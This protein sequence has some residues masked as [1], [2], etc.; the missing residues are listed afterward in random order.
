MKKLLRYGLILTCTLLCSAQLC[1]ADT[2][3]KFGLSEIG[4]DVQFDGT[5]FSTSNDGD[6]TTPGD[7]NT[8]L[9]FVGP[10]LGV[11]PDILAGAS[12]SI[13][14]VVIDGPALV[15]GPSVT[16]NTTGGTFSVWDD[17][18]N[19]LLTG[20]LD[21]SVL[22][23]SLIGSTGSYFNTSIVTLTGGSLLPF[24]H[25]DSGGLS[26]ALAGINSAGGGHLSVDGT[27]LLP[28]S[29]NADGLLEGEPIPEPATGLL[30]LTGGALLARRRKAA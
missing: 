24:F 25:P 18:D 17:N 5:T 27:T 7:Q 12:L 8:G 30:L 14:G 15:I 4:P 16:Q 9:N 11:F 10:L 13:S 23:G 20:A 28:F 21:S 22:S 3:L 1:L 2:I 29:A 6:A 19:L 26:L